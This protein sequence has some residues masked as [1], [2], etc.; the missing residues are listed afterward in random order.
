MTNEKIVEEVLHKAYYEGIYD[1][2][3][4]V[5]EDIREEEGIDLNDSFIEAYNRVN[6][7]KT[8]S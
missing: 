6:S 7:E 4:K 5:S 1:L 8:N 3:C 2:V